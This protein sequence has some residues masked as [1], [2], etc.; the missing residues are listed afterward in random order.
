M[1]EF[2]IFAL[3]E[4]PTVFVLPEWEV[5]LE[6][7]YSL[8]STITMKRR[9]KIPKKAFNLGQSSGVLILEATPCFL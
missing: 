1:P 9:L 6:S 7:F 8:A 2:K 5:M 4:T 3:F